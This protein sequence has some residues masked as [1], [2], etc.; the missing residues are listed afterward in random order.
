MAVEK[1]IFD[2]YD[3]DMLKS[4]ILDFKDIGQGTIVGFRP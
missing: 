1:I 4:Y 3:N 2:N